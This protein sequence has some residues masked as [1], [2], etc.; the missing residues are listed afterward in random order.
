MMH[1]VGVL[2]LCHR[3]YWRISPIP[4]GLFASNRTIIRLPR[5]GQSYYCPIIR[6]EAL[7]DMETTSL[8]STKNVRYNHHMTA[9]ISMTQPR[10][11]CAIISH[12][13]V[14]ADNAT[15]T[16][17]RAIYPCEIP[18]DIRLLYHREIHSTML[19]IPGAVKYDHFGITRSEP[20]KYNAIQLGKTRGENDL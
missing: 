14:R 15:T 19:L 10:T 5:L 9:L 4:S 1:I 16:Q 2:V 6:E 18:W 13:F 7:N 11:I 12:T 17:Y 3:C 8:E 20:S